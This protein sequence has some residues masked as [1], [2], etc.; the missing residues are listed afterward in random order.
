MTVDWKEAARLTRLRADNDMPQATPRVPACRACGDDAAGAGM[1]YCVNHRADK[2]NEQ[3][4]AAG[5]HLGNW[6]VGRNR[7]GNP[8]WEPD[9]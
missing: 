6:R 2:T 9:R 5:E 7:F 4:V 1:L 3:L 8:T